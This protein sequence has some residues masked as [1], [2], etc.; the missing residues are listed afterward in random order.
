M[1]NPHKWLFTPID[2]SLLYCR[3]PEMLRAAFSLTPEYLWTPEGKEGRN[4]MDFGVSLGRR[5]R[6][7]KLWFVL[8]YFG[9]DGIRDRIREH[10][11]LASRFADRIDGEPGWVRVA[12]T[13]FSTV[14]FRSNP[15]GLTGEEADRLN[16]DIMDRVN[17]T[18]RA[19]LS[20]TRLDGRIALRLAVGNLRTRQEHLDRT[21]QLLQAEAAAVLAG[22]G[23]TQR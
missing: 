4:L 6:A 15:P 20:H 10:C 8:R 3:R 22:A 7:L 21:W 12:P 11:R 19:F 9:S 18:G 2:C 13:P 1:V 16:L 23:H 17:A 5:F 14:V